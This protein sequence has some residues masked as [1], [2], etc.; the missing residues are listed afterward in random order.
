MILQK[1]TLKQEQEVPNG[2]YSISFMYKKLIEVAN[3]TVKINEN[4]YQ[5]DSLDYEQFY[6]GKTNEDGDYIIFPIEVTAGHISIEFTSDSNNSVEIYDIMCNKGSVKLAWSQ[7]ENEVTTDTVNISKGIT[8]TSS[9]ME[10]IFKA[11]ANGIKILTLQGET[12]AYFT[13]KGL[14]TK[15]AIIEE[16]AE[17]CGTLITDVGDQTWFTRM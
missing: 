4:I 17:I 14:T 11:N 5:L 2:N 16:K 13:E 3:A 12:I 15:E 7:N 1:G 10:T 8:I 6:T 9:Y